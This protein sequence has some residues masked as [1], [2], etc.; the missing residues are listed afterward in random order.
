MC[1]NPRFVSQAHPRSRGENMRLTAPSDATLGSS[2]LTRGKRA[3]LGW[4][5]SVRGLIPAHA[6]KTWE[7][8]AASPMDR[9]HPRSR[10]ENYQY[11]LIRYQPS[12]SSPLTRGKPL[13]Y[14]SAEGANRLIPAH[15]GKTRPET[16]TT[17]SRPAHPRSRGENFPLVRHDS[18]P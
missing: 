9:A 13:T 2:P 10:G 3:A 5:R 17:Q 14:N 16:P 6:G 1:R 11:H 12:G 18:S 15:A 4:G 8:S 7:T